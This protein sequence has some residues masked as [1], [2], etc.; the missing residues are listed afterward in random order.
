MDDISFRRQLLDI[1]DARFE[2]PKLALTV[3]ISSQCVV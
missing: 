2:K 3:S 1:R